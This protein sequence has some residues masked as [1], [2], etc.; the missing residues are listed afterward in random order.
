MKTCVRWAFILRA[1]LWFAA[2][3]RSQVPG[4]GAF[5]AEVFSHWLVALEGPQ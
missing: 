3:T 1:L 5:A 4:C 2:P